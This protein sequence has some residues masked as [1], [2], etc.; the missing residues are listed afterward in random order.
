MSKSRDNVLTK[1]YSGKFGDQIVYRVCEEGE[2]VMAKPP[3][4]SKRP[5]TEA[6][7]DLRDKFKLA[8]EWAQVALSDP[9][10]LAQYEAMVK[11]RRTPYVLA[12]RNFMRPPRVTEI[13][14]T[15]YSGVI[16]STITVTAKDDFKI[17]GVKVRIK[18]STGTLIEEG[19]CVRSLATGFWTYTATVAVA[20]LTGVVVTA[21]AKDYPEHTGTL[22]VTL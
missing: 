10:M 21:I 14:T 8:I 15:E 19:N 3:K 5:I 13:N 4:R 1:T 6:Q 2:S 17:L 16:G 22:S 18:D 12:I 9:D 11:G 7:A 20:N